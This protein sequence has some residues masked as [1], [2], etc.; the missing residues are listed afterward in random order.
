MDFFLKQWQE[1]SSVKDDLAMRDWFYAT[2]GNLSM[3]L[4]DSPLTFLV[5]ANGKDKRKRD[6]DDFIVV[7]ELGERV[8]S[9]DREPS[10]ETYLHTIIY[11][12]TVANCI[13]HVHTVYNN[14]ISELYFNKGVIVFS[15]H[16]M[17]KKYYE[18]SIKQADVIVIPIIE[19]VSDKAEFEKSFAR[20]VLSD[21]GAI[22]VHNH[23]LTVWASSAQAAKK[24]LEALEF[25]FQYQTILHSTKIQILK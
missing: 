20:Q 21:E 17:V 3:R 23:G 5:T 13:L 16:E 1:L 19:N 14:V 2:T 18:D 12:K 10:I 15:N 8:F 11:E 7:N 6:D 25:L 22:L 24:K 9:V 4:T